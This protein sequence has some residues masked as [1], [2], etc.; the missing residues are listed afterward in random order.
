MK[1]R[2]MKTSTSITIISCILACLSAA[3]AKSFVVS[4]G[5]SIQQAIDAA[6]AGDN[7][8]VQTGNYDESLSINKGL[9]IRGAG[10]AVVVTGTLSVSNADLPVYIADMAF[11][12]SGASGITL[13]GAGSQNVRMDRCKLLGGGRLSCTG[14]TGYFYRLEFDGNVSFTTSTWTFQR[15]T[16]GGNL[17]STDSLAKC[18]ASKVIGSFTHSGPAAKEITIFQSDLRELA[19]I[20][21][22]GGQSGWICYSTL[23]ALNLVGGTLQI[24]GNH[25]SG[26][27]NDYLVQLGN[28]CHAELRNNHFFSDGYGQYSQLWVI[29][30]DGTNLTDVSG[31]TDY[32]SRLRSPY[33]ESNNSIFYYHYFDYALRNSDRPT[34]LTAY[35]KK[36]LVFFPAYGA[37]DSQMQSR[38]PQNLTPA[39]TV[40]EPWH[41]M[42]GGTTLTTAKFALETSGTFGTGAAAIK[43]LNGAGSI[44]VFNNTAVD[45]CQF[46]HVAGSPVGIEIRGNIHRSLSTDTQRLTALGYK[47]WF[48]RMMIE[49]G[50]PEDAIA[51]GLYTVVSN[52]GTAGTTFLA[53]ESV[54]SSYTG[55]IISDNNFEFPVIGGQASNNVNVDPALRLGP[56]GEINWL[57]NS[58]PSRDLGP[59][60]ALY[61]DL[62]ASRN[63]QGAY[64]GHSY[65]PTGRTTLKPVVLSG[66]VAPLYVKRGSAVTIKARA[67]VAAEP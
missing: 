40:E 9:D 13:S 39:A 35:R 20:T 16:V 23:R 53:R 60:D 27:R 33:L 22:P 50:V 25:I 57:G 41:W 37:G 29:R 66:E 38:Y 52:R 30:H 26:L 32:D 44:R 4:P 61:N 45:V 19:S 11:G 43:V 17:T 2:V 64:G 63:D 58:S 34:W 1:S 15:C 14:T 54:R 47:H 67:A 21:L 49:Q 7:I 18:I 42:T 8:T 56:S 62:D 36:E 46:V 31:T 55:T 24:T 51:A 28:A 48:F 5:Q 10:G 12:K 65:D 3:H 6:S 59:V